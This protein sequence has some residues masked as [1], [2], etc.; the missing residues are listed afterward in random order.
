MTAVVANSNSNSYY[1]YSVPEPATAA[2][3]AGVL[4]LVVTG[5]IRRRTQAQRRAQLAAA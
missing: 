2:A 5:L 3:I 1:Y 4:T